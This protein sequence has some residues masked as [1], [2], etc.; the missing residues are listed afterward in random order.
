MKHESTL[1]R[2]AGDARGLTPRRAHEDLVVQ[3]SYGIEGG[4]SREF[5]PLYMF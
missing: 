4:N 3:S 5:H 2:F 1:L